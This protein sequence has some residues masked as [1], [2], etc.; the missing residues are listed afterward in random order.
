MRLENN[1][2]DSERQTRNTTGEAEQVPEEAYFRN[3]SL[4]KAAFMDYI[5]K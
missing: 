1:R 4:Y 2:I 5:H 3:V